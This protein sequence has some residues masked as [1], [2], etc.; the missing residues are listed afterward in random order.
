MESEINVWVLENARKSPRHA[1]ERNVHAHPV[2]R[3]GDIE[4]KEPKTFE[5]KKTSTPGLL[6][7]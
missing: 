3:V 4:S 5:H 7:I 1:Q 6:Q 2:G